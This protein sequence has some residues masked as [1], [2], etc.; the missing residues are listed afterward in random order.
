MKPTF[1]GCLG[2]EMS[3]ISTPVPE[4]SLET[5]SG[6]NLFR[7]AYFPNAATSA[8]P[9]S[10]LVSRSL[11]TSS[12]FLLPGS[13]IPGP[14]GCSAMCAGGRPSSGFQVWWP[15]GIAAAAPPAAASVTALSAAS[16]KGLA[17]RGMYSP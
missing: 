2:L 7:Y 8:M 9:S 11:L 5:H 14:P 17:Q 6:E 4:P 13:S 16:S 3:T 10:T 12:M 1:L 15:G